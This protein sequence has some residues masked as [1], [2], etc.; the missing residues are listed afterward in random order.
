MALA[1][2]A[3]SRMDTDKLKLIHLS[4]ESIIQKQKITTLTA[5]QEIK[6]TVKKEGSTPEG[7][8]AIRRVQEINLEAQQVLWHID[9]LKQMIVLNQDISSL[10]RQLD[11]QLEFYV[12]YIHQSYE[13]LYGN[14]FE[15][16]FPAINFTGSEQF[17]PAYF[18]SAEPLE[19]LTSLDQTALKVISYETEII[20]RLGAANICGTCYEPSYLPFGFSKSDV[21]E[22]GDDYQVELILSPT[23]GSSSNTIFFN[24]KKYPMV[25]GITNI[26]IPAEKAGTFSWKVDFPFMFKGR[27][28]TLH[29]EGQYEVIKK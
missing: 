7:M 20:K 15:K 26:F 8:K 23:R 4:F 2:C 17:N 9:S 13:D 21:V 28:T 10:S 25:N 1:S 24:D 14:G 16:D 3:E 11:H 22:L 18:S 27:D 12:A 6:K 29:L 5:I 19:A